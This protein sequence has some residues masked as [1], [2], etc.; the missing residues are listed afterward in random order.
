MFLLAIPPFP[1]DFPNDVE[2]TICRALYEQ[3]A[4]GHVDQAAI[5]D[6][7]QEQEK[8]EEAASVLHTDLHDIRE[9]EDPAKAL[10]EMVY[11][12]IIERLNNSG[13]ADEPAMSLQE[14]V[15]RRKMAEKIR[16]MKLTL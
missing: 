5:V 2:Q 9:A 10:T 11:Q 8:Q 6:R 7:F 4:L 12:V 1:E 14:I 16:T 13:N 15:E 3:S